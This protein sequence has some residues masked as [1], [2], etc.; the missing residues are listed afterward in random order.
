[1][2]GFLFLKSS[3]VGIV[4]ILLLASIGWLQFSLDTLH[5]RPVDQIESLAQL[6]KGQ[7][8]KRVSLGYHHLGAD[9]LWLRLVQVLGKK[10]NTADEYEWMAHRV[11]LS[12]RIL[13]KGH[14]ANPTVW[15]LPFD[16][17]YNHFFYLGDPGKAAD[18]IAQ[19]AHLPG[20]PSYL[21]GLATRMYAEAQNP[22]VAL[23]FLA[24]MWAQTENTFVMS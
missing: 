18:Y 17:G 10:R 12:N 19:A 21:P 15:R 9:L 2:K 20:R 16:L 14:E 1:M 22:D 3:F 7:Y 8:L 24:A 11:D 4:V 6:P 23:D 13:E 5:D